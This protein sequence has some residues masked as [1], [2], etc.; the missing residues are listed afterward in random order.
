MGGSPAGAK[1]DE[2][3]NLL[4]Q[5]LAL[6]LKLLFLRPIKQEKNLELWLVTELS[7]WLSPMLSGLIILVQLQK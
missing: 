6:R 4:S 1:S 2:I 7:Q 5:R 3:E